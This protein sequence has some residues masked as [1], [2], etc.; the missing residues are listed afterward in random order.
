[1]G[2]ELWLQLSLISPL[3][4]RLLEQLRSLSHK[5]TTQ[6][7]SEEARILVFALYKKEA[8]RVESMLK[9]QGYSVG[10]LHGDMTQPARMEALEA[11]KNGKTGLLV[12]TDVAARGLD[13]P[14]VGAVINYTFPLTIEDYIHRIGRTGMW[15][16]GQML[17]PCLDPIRSWWPQREVDY[18]LHW[19][20]SRTV[21]SWRAGSSVARE[22]L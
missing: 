21:F 19:G 3:S 17:G 14:N 15:L 22:W 13:I 20:Q 6:T 8:S 2:C 4:S 1:V 18:V 11:F 12:A 16:T 9:R 7:G 10:A 5:K